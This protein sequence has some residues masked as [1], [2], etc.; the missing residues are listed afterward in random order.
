M[1]YLEDAE[2]ENTSRLSRFED[3]GKIDTEDQNY[4]NALFK[5]EQ[6]K[7]AKDFGMVPASYSIV[8]RDLPGFL[9]KHP[10]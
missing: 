6:I 10:Q 8:F 7:E 3:S 9:E 4:K 5:I 2:V 1:K